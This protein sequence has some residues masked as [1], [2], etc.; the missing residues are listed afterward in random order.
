MNTKESLAQTKVRLGIQLLDKKVP[1]WRSK[2]NTKVD[3]NDTL[4]DLKFD[5]NKFPPILSRILLMFCELHLR[6][7]KEDSEKTK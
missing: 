6:K 7:I 1:D 3:N 5:I 4:V 2:I